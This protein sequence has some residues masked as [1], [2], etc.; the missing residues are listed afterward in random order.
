M[1]MHFRVKI[2]YGNDDFI[3]IDQDELSRAIVAQGTGKVAVFKEGTVGGNHIMAIIP[4]YQR[5]LGYARD[6]VLHGHDYV[7]LGN[8]RIDEHREAIMTATE[9]ANTQIGGNGG[10][11][12][13]KS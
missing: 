9:A 4:D 6:Y 7:E 11:K 1:T 3:S 12:L 5:A 8:K 10:Q 13:L 2:G